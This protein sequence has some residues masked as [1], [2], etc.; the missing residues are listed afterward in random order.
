MPYWLDGN[1]LIGQSVSRA[2]EDRQTRSQ[3]LALI[4]RYAKF[5]RT[6]ITVYFDGDDPDRRAAPQG[7]QVR[8]SAPVSTDD[9]ILRKLHGSRIPSEVI[10]VTNDATLGN[11][12]ISAGAKCISWGEFENR[13]N[14][15]ETRS[16]RMEKTE[17]AVDI[18]DWSR[19]F[20]F[21][22]NLED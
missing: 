15:A 7:V 18:K 2:R 9:A 17:K 4:A 3:F 8:F 22:D 11:A 16:R 10:V 1:N 20:G 12:C 13:M 21:N 6:T 19:Y 5:R 14:R